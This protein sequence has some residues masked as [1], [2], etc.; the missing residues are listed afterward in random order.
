MHGTYFLMK[1]L[2]EADRND[3][4]YEM[5]T[6][7]DYPGWGYMLAN[8]ATTSWEGWTGQSHIHDTLI[9]IGAWFTEGLAGIQ[10]DGTSPGFKH[11]VIKPA[12]V[13]DLTFVK[14]KYN[15]IHGEIIS[16]WRI[17]N[18]TFKLSVTV[19]P[20]TT[21]TVFVPGK[22]LVRT[23]ERRSSDRSGNRS[24]EIAPGTHSFETAL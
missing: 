17:D 8:G 3:L 10:S 4:V 13:G 1:Y 24:F 7:T 20:G 19:P 21:A 2:L 23:A 18:G 6:K 14:G 9:S 5:T 22:G 16:D 11:F 15:S 12:V